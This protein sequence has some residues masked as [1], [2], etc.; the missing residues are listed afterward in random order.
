MKILHIGA[1]N[2]NIG[3][4]IAILNARKCWSTLNPNIEW[5]ESDIGQF[6]NVYIN[7]RQIKNYFKDIE[8]KGFDAILFGGGGL[9]EYGGYEHYAS[10]WKLPFNKEVL[11]S[12]NIPVYF[13]A[14]GV[15]IFRGGIEYSDKA[16]KALQET[17]ELAGGFSVRNDGSYEKLRDWIGLDVSNVDV[18]ADPGMLFLDGFVEKKDTVK[19]GGI[20]PAFN[21]S[22]GINRQRFKSKEN[23]DYISNL[24]KDMICYPHVTKDYNRINAKPVVSRED[25]T[26]L[27]TSDK[28]NDFLE[29]YKKIDYVI[30]MRGHGQLITIGMGL[31]GLYFTTQDKVRDFSLLNGFEDYNIDIEDENWKQKLEDKIEL[32]TQPNSEYLKKW[33]EIREEQLEKWDKSTINTIT[34][35]L[36]KHEMSSMSLGE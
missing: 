31:P 25:F 10:G 6:W 5:F 36:A 9:I 2:R 34:K 11:E 18:I 1:Y 21:G 7:I 33:Y 27:I 17:I 4:T 26:T 8:E 28:L 35:Y 16:K 22:E 29:L 23:I 30:A 19:V 3:D 15:N 24:T 13:H 32:L 20:Q 12:F 14:I